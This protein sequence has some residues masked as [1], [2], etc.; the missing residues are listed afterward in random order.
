MG[1]FRRRRERP[2]QSQVI[3]VSVLFDDDDG[4]MLAVAT[5][6]DLVEVDVV[7]ES[8]HQD[9]LEQVAGP[10]SELTKHYQVGTTLRCD[11]NNPYDSNAIRVECMGQ[12]VGFIPRQTAALL[13][14]CMHAGCGGVLEA[15]GF[16]VGGWDNGISTGFYGIRVWVK[17]ED[18]QRIGVS[19]ASI[20]RGD[21]EPYRGED[22]EPPV[23]TGRG[24]R[25]LDT[26][27]SEA[28]PPG[29]EPSWYLD[30][31]EADRPAIEMLRKVL[32]Q[33]GDPLTRHFQ[34]AELEHRLYHARELY[35]SALDEF[36]STCREHDGE[37][38]AMR[39]VFL[40]RWGQVPRLDLYRQM[41]IRQSKLHDWNAVI[42]WAERGLAIYG[43]DA[44]REVAVED[45]IKRRNHANAKLNGL[46]KGPPRARA[47]SALA[48]TPEIEDLECHLCGATFQRVRVKGR[49]P[50]LCPDCRAKTSA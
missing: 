36:D 1:L 43:S 14:S 23:E 3:T 27:F 40:D 37:M 28:W 31:P 49:K 41:S 38:D 24:L 18:L 30:L 19:P 48:A 26:G 4:G 21:K 12:H 22:I 29:A 47:H 8:H 13:S 17:K 5:D 34:Y 45:L 44:A 20:G 11:P 33:D 32:T 35:D 6:P 2:E 9:A 7:G 25:H 50:H 39:L 16:I 42:W 10:P 15:V 46:P